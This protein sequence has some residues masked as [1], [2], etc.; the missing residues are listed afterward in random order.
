METCG[1]VQGKMEK[2]CVRER[3]SKLKRHTLRP[4]CS[5]NKRASDMRLNQ[6]ET[7]AASTIKT[8]Q[9]FPHNTIIKCFHDLTF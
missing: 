5:F 7:T 9:M 3:E 2:G 8:S 1:M 4:T 6:R